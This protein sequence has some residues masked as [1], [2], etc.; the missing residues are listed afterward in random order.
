VL[1]LVVL[2]L[3]VLL[4]NL[5]THL[6]THYNALPNVEAALENTSWSPSSTRGHN[7][8]LPNTHSNL[9]C[10]AR[11]TQGPL[12]MIRPETLKTLSPKP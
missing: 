12:P 2:L 8:L 1:L 11:H 4:L 3:V 5:T 9:T 6:P 7:Q 10:S